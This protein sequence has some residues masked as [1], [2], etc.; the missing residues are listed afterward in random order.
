MRQMTSLALVFMSLVLGG[1]RLI[2]AAEP[3]DRPNI[4][5][6]TSED[7]S[8][9]WMGCYGNEQASTP[10]IDR[11]AAT[12]IRY[13]YAY[14]NAAVCAVAR[15]TLILG[16]YACGMGTQNM[17][18]RYPV[19][20]RFQTYPAYLREA[21]YY[22]V[23]RSKTDYNFKTDDKS[24]WDQ[25]GGQAHWK[26][27]AEGQP[28]FAVFNSTISHESSLF[29]NKT[30]DFRRR[31]LIPEVPRRDPASV[32]LPPH[33]P[34]TPELRQ[35]WVTYMDVI[36]AMDQQIGGWIQELDDAGVRE[37]TII[38]YYAD[39]GGIL[40][41]AKRYINDTGNHIPLIV[42]FPKKWQHLAPQGAGTVSDRVVSFIDFPAT[43]LSLAGVGV[44]PEFQGHAF[45]GEGAVEGGPY[46]FL[47]GQRFDARMLRFVRGV[48]DGEYRYI[49][50]FYPHRHR[51]IFT[52]YPHGQVGWQSLFKLKQEGALQPIQQAYWVAPQ[53]AEELYF[54]GNDPWELKN[55]A[56]DPAHRERLEAMR[57][58]T[59]NQMREIG[60]TGIVP[61]AMYPGLSANGTVYGYVHNDRFPYDEVLDL[62]LTASSSNGDV[63]ETLKQALKHEHPVFRFWGATG[64]AIQGESCRSA[65]RD[66]QTL[67]EDEVPVVRIAAAEALFVLGE[68]QQGFDAL[69]DVLQ[70]N[71]EE[72]TALE[73]LNVCQALGIMD[74]VP[75]EAWAR[76]CETGSY[77]KGMAGDPKNP[78]LKS[79]TRGVA[80]DFSATLK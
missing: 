65:V 25:C 62:A 11:L 60:D 69:V 15:N 43:V 54:T 24:H 26:N 64:C 51:G 19:P 9:H 37:N 5:W 55:L 63:V 73:A 29:A 70:T 27:R 16:R 21:G 68:K 18:S 45:A 41:R 4:L 78:N 14:S 57:A 33:Y 23:N 1:Q 74:Q 46:A 17:R 79:A 12:G 20:D 40:P 6:V 42:S 52:G 48:T 36:S 66:L 71:R 53:P 72:I 32:E 39:H 80:P 31:G 61:E 75:A 10:H 35:D 7:N 22:C 49:R 56:N 28:F 38:F 58:A 77:T 2:A 59:L 8:Y 13:R 67:L 34:D 76:A 3:A 47:F 44:P 50:N 30:K